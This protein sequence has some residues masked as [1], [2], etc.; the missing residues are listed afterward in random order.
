MTTHRI[1]RL[2]AAVPVAELAEQDVFVLEARPRLR[3]HLVAVPQ[4][5]QGLFGGVERGEAAGDGVPQARASQSRAVREL[6][7][8]L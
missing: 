3:R 4:M 8:F 6:A 5:M 1:T 7:L 2:A